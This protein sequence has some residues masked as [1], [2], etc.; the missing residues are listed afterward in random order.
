[1]KSQHN[2]FLIIVKHA[3]LKV[4]RDRIHHTLVLGDV[5]FSYVICHGNSY[6]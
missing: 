3:W 2:N 6:S 1:M 5:D 4:K